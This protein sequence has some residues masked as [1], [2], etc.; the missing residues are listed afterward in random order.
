M[1]LGIAFIVLLVLGSAVEVYA[2]TGG[3]WW[4]EEKRDPRNFPPPR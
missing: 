3:H 1:L 4:H 2:Y